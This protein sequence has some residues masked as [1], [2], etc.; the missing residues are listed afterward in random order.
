MASIGIDFGTTYC[1]VAAYKDGKVNIIPNDQDKARTLSYVAFT[2]AE[3]LY[4]DAAVHQSFTNMKN[5]VYDIKH[6]LGRCYD[7]PIVLKDV[8]KWGFEVVD[9]GNKPVITV[10]Y[11]NE[12]NELNAEQIC[13][14]LLS[15]SKITAEKYLCE[16]VIDA[17]VSVP[18]NFSDAQRTAV[19][20]AGSIAGIN[21]KALINEAT[22]SAIAFGS[23]TKVTSI[24]NLLVFDLGGGFF[25]VSV[26]AVKDCVFKILATGGDTHFGGN[27]ID[28]RMVEHFQKQFEHLHDIDMS[29]D[30]KALNRL[31]VAC[32]KAKR[33]LS[34]TVS[35]SL[36]VDGFSGKI[37]FESTIT[38]EIFDDINKD[39]FQKAIDIVKSV[40]HDANIDESKIDEIILV[41]GSSRIPK[42]R[43]MLRELF[44]GKEL[45]KTVNPDEAVALGAAFMSDN[46]LNKEYYV[47]DITPC[48][49]GVRIPCEKRDMMIVVPRC[50]VFPITKWINLACI[51]KNNSR[52][53][54]ALEIHEGES[55]WVKDN[56]H[57][58]TIKAHLLP[59][60]FE[61]HVSVDHMGMMS[62]QVFQ[63]NQIVT[64]LHVEQRGRLDGSELKQMAA[65]HQQLQIVDAEW[66]EQSEARNMLENF[67]YSVKQATRDRRYKNKWDEEDKKRI[68]HKCD[69]TLAWIEANWNAKLDE[70]HKKR[71]ELANA[72]V[73]V[74]SKMDTEKSKQLQQHEEKRRQQF[75]KRN[76]LRTQM[77]I[78]QKITDGPNYNENSVPGKWIKQTYGRI[79]HFFFNIKQE[80]D[81][82][83][84]T[85]Q[86][87]KVIDDFYEEEEQLGMAKMENERQIYI[88]ETKECRIRIRDVYQTMNSDKYRN[89]ITIQEKTETVNLIKELK[90]ALDNDLELEVIQQR[91]TALSQIWGPTFTRVL[92]KLE[93]EKQREAKASLN[94]RLRT[95]SIENSETYPL[96]TDPE[97]NEVYEMIQFAGSENHGAE[98]YAKLEKRSVELLNSIASR[99]DD[100]GKTRDAR[101]HLEKSIE[102]LEAAL[103]HEEY[104]GIDSSSELEKLFYFK[105]NCQQ[106]NNWSFKEYEAKKEEV[107]QVWTNFLAKIAREREKDM[108]AFQNGIEDLNK[109]AAKFQFIVSKDDEK[110]I[111]NFNYW[112]FDN[113]KATINEIR[114]KRAEVNLKI[115]TLTEKAEKTSRK[116][117]SAI[118]AM[119]GTG[120]GRKYDERKNQRNKHGVIQCAISDTPKF[121][122]IN[123]CL[124]KCNVTR[125]PPEPNNARQALSTFLNE[126]SIRS[127]E[128]DFD[129]KLTK[130]ET[131]M[132]RSECDKT[133]KWFSQNPCAKEQDFQTKHQQLR[134]LWNEISQK[135]K[136]N[137]CAHDCGLPKNATDSPS[138]HTSNFNPSRTNATRPKNKLASIVDQKS[139]EAHNKGKLK[140]YHELI[141]RCFSKNG[142]NRNSLTRKEKKQI[143][144]LCKDTAKLLQTE[145]NIP[146]NRYAEALKQLRDVGDPMFSRFNKTTF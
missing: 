40:I 25:D 31:R 90:D 120:D 27:N 95:L 97:K 136:E 11:K 124:A 29:K 65:V 135:F 6:L 57:T 145:A 107:Q 118:E 77:E 89:E 130:E 10:K 126:L 109:L 99:M 52:R 87:N 53:V 127:H 144:E 134:K 66:K 2:E 83:E 140:N 94:E 92:D 55:N 61:L 91:K 14:M 39:L 42:I 141:V 125:H 146:E 143:D 71:Q 84:L 59:G 8:E 47:S 3:R 44:H 115:K 28:D 70:S 5:T 15:Q 49:I 4:D 117:P 12:N 22:A 13:A 23:K 108:A 101:D 63:K 16:E 79:K 37:D 96:L 30:K 85:K 46:F 21:I 116:Q 51:G 139:K 36:R 142:F 98:E 45:N 67:T 103:K 7:D 105:K 132:I 72:W 123:E 9:R 73:T 68:L 75:E 121:K 35:A 81:I 102:E 88:E 133:H 56:I 34:E 1:T 131:K 137:E 80:E 86:A 60:N 129:E 48:S 19:K 69:D 64:V 100:K 76:T 41:G 113:K 50:S 20:D 119:E 138:I 33:T 104:E 43:E 62:F 58:C 54:L 106:K 18:S 24:C 114:E 38:R 128:K 93:I 111:H 78:Y 26:V 110:D 17:V 74:L 82:E 122:T 112:C 32:E